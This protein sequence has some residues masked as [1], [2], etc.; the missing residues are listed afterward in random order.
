MEL[1]KNEKIDDLELNGLKIIQNKNQFCFGID[2]V[3]LS[4]FA[5]DI[6]KNTTVL[7]LGT[8][9]GII[10]ILLSSKCE[11]KKI[12]GVEL[13]EEVS[14]LARRNIEL[15]KLEN[16]IEIINDDILNID[17]YFAIE[18][19]E[20]VVTNPP[21]KKDNTGIKNDLEEKIIAR[22]ETTADLEKFIVIAKKMLKDKGAI[23]MIH[24]PE[25]ISE[26]IYLM[27][28]NKLEP[29]VMRLVSSKINNEPKMVLIKGIKN[30]KEFLKIES[31]LYI[32]NEDNT[33][34]DE[35]KKI[36]NKN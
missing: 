18:S 23:Y 8:G 34:T 33:Y 10:P 19:F 16:R 9:N 24:R 14:K 31:N 32:Y 1:N 7:E 17:K 35:I 11:C 20:S 30:A 28:K 12:I 22:H 2:A 25:R 29:K 27:K 3:L 5:K 4:D 13:Q 21:Y 36:Y 15:N 6:K 26:I